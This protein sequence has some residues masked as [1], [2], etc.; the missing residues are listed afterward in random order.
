[1]T[2]NREWYKNNYQHILE[3]NK[4][5]KEKN[6]AQ[7]KKWHN[8]NSKDY[9]E[10][11]K[12]QIALRRSIFYFENAER[13]SKE[14]KNWKKYNPEKCLQHHIT[15]HQKYGHSLGF[16]NWRK[17]KYALMAWSDTIQKR[18]QN[19]CQVCGNPSKDS[20]HLIYKSIEP[21]LSLNI[22]NGI[23]LCENCHKECHYGVVAT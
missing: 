10:S 8:K 18:E 9:Y 14:N 19:I 17:F 15:H 16:P 12:K 13:L 1:M 6:P 22:N 21:K 7:Y 2:F 5:Y 3:Y 20:H 23:S 11:H 4:K